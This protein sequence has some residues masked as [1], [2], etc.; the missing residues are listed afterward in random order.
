MPFPPIDAQHFRLGTSI[1]SG[2][3]TPQRD[4]LFSDLVTACSLGYCNNLSHFGEVLW[5]YR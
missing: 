4:V 1:F 5:P 3:L 2:L